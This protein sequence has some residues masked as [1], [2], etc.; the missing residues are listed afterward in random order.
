MWDTKLN[1]TALMDEFFT[2][3]YGPAAAPAKAFW[4]EME[5]A[6][7]QSPWCG[8]EDHVLNQVYT[9]ALVAK[10]EA[11]LTQAE[12]AA[13]GNAWAAPRVSADR[14][15]FDHLRA[16]Q[17]MVRAE[18]NAD[19]A[20]AAKQAQRMLDLRQP[21]TELSRFYFDPQPKTGESYGFYYWG[22]VSRRKYYEKMANLTTN[23]VAVLSERAKFAVDPRDEGRF[24][25]WF[26]P[27]FDDREWKNILTT[28]PFYGQGPWMDEQGFPYLGALWYRL[29][30]KLPASVKGKKVSLYC[31]AAETEAWV[32]VNGQFIGH[33][34]YIEAYLRPN[35]I[36]LDVTDALLPGKNNVIAIRLHTNYQPAQMAAGLVSRL[37]LYEP[38]R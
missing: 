33:R 12:A 25:G 29:E 17:A 13:A 2:N 34:P 5:N 26:Q 3:W 27:D 23:M 24:D 35:A 20:E 14:V 16:Y 15:T 37:L 31:A 18:F 6:I 38:V 7:E 11:H 28:V 8:N 1:A 32:W 19:F 21:A 4:E 9:P 10:L 30:T 22:A 36:D